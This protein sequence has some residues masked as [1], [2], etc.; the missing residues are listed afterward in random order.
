M[1]IS[2]LKA[3]YNARTY[4]WILNPILL[5]IK[6]NLFKK[7]MSHCNSGFEIVT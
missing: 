7:S 4:K 1:L 3:E 6:L 2:A 5:V